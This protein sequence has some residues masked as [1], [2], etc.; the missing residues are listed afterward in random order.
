MVEAIR[1]CFLEV[2]SLINNGRDTAITP[3]GC[4][5]IEDSSDGVAAAKQAVMKC[6]AVTNT[7]SGRGAL[8]SGSHSRYVA[9]IRST[10]GPLVRAEL[11]LFAPS[12]LGKL[13]HS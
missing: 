6:L 5:V 4:L 3:A 11:G 7:H 13:A 8:R 9:W 10:Q 1:S 12:S 2:L